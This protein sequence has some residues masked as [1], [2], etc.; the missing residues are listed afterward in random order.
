MGE[1]ELVVVSS[2]PGYSVAGTTM[3]SKITGRPPSFSA[4]CMRRVGVATDG[5]ALC[6]F[7]FGAA[8]AKRQQFVHRQFLHAILAGD[9]IEVEQ[10]AV[11]GVSSDEGA[12]ALLPHQYIGRDQRIDGFADSP[13]GNVKTARQH[14]LAGDRFVGFPVACRSLRVNA[15]CTCR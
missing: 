5:E 10:R 9:V 3:S 4:F 12:L 13:C 6:F 11:F 7:G 14:L 8:F 1:K 2:S 15:I